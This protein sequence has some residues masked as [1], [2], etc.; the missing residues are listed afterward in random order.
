MPSDW[1]EVLLQRFAMLPVFMG[2]IWVLISVLIFIIVS[3]CSLD[4]FCSISD[5]LN[6]L[7]DLLLRELF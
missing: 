6:W 7:L 1:A 4:L 3:L 2:R 5:F